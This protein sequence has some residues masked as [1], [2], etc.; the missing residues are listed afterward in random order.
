MSN[1]ERADPWAESHGKD[2]P[3]SIATHPGS[4][5][6]RTNAVDGVSFCAILYLALPNLIFLYG[7]FKF[8]VALAMN[9]LLLVFLSRLAPSRPI[10]W[11]AGYS[12]SAVALIL[13]LAAI[14]AAFGGGS[15]FVYANPDW[16]VR[17]AVLG[18]LVNKTWP[19]GYRSPNGEPALLRSAI[20]YFLPLALF[21]KLFGSAHMDFAVFAW[22]TIG[23]AL[24]FLL[25]PLERKVSASLL[26]G[27]AITIFFS[28]MD[29]VGQVISTQALPMFPLRLEWWG[30]LSYP[31]LSV[32]L[33]W[34]PNHCLPI[35]IGTLLMLR[36]WDQASLLKIIT[37]VI[38]LSLV[39]TPFA[40]LGLVPFALLGG[41]R[42]LNRFDVRSVPWISIGAAAVFSLPICLFLLLDVGHID[43]GVANQGA[44]AAQ[45][46]AP[47]LTLNQY[48]TFVSCEFLLL[49]LVLAPLI[50]QRRDVFGLALLIL[51]LL[52]LVGY[53]PSN[54]L[55]L[56]LSTP[57]LMVLL[58]ICL[59]TLFIDSRPSI[60]ST[61][62]MAWIFLAIGAHSGFNELWRAATYHGWRADYSYSLTDRTGGHLPAHYVGQ[63]GDSALLGSLLRYQPEAGQTVRK[64]P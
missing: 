43:A 34:A 36:H 53:G 31:S 25:L 16:V 49:A 30:P 13:V 12:R 23:A 15:H 18:D 1:D 9:L 63:L 60:Q 14:W 7:W 21:G 46:T 47:L 32:Q 28:G 24:F 3:V 39:W 27:I 57:P 51:M 26:I 22:T 59:Q 11:S 62:W 58:V 44:G 5:A 55:L 19:V 6:T 35:W 52:P 61:R 45:R 50:R 56:R 20:G 48:L 41:L 38:P 8:P 33:L 4:C 29:Y 42:Y 2:I 40:A 37:A 54:D 64:E 17:D 10:N